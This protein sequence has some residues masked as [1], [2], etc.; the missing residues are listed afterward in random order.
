[1]GPG[2]KNDTGANSPCTKT[3]GHIGGVLGVCVYVCVAS[4]GQQ[5]L[6]ALLPRVCEELLSAVS[7]MG[8]FWLA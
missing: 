8:L 3:T 2:D 1:M 4:S 5:G 7:G 6:T